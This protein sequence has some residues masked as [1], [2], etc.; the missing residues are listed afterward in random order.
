MLLYVVVLYLVVVC[1]FQA[2][3]LLELSKRLVDIDKSS[4]W[5]ELGQLLVDHAVRNAV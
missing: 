4:D 2:L 5:L 3:H 1:L